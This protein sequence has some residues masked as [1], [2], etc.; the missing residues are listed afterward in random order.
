MKTTFNASEIYNA[1]ATFNADAYCV[2]TEEQVNEIMAEISE[3]G[4]EEI[5][6]EEDKAVALSRLDLAEDAEVAVYRAG[7]CTFAVE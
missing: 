2:E 1:V 7:G 6:D 5:T 4:V 3:Y